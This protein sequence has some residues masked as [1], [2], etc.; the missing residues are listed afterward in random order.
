[1]TITIEPFPERLLRGVPGNPK[2]EVWTEG[3]AD[4]FTTAVTFSCTGGQPDETWQ[5]GEL[6]RPPGHTTGGKVKD[7]EAPKIYL[8]F[9]NTLMTAATDKTMTINVQIYEEQ[10]GN[11]V[12]L[13]RR[14]PLWTVTGKS[15]ELAKTTLE[16]SMKKTGE[17][18]NDA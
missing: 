17:G 12:I 1:M 4:E 2:L 3:G 11:R 7:L 18:S 14:M 6:Y 8:L 5:H 16:I 9:C 13:R 15:G 10:N